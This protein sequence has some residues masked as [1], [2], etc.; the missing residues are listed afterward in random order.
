MQEKHIFAQHPRLQNET[1]I[2]VAAS[3]NLFK[4]FIVIYFAYRRCKENAGHYGFWITSKFTLEIS[5][6]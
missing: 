1:D 2:Y 3:D 6:K 5:K 4:V